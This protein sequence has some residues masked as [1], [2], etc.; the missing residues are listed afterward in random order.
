MT[1]VVMIAKENGHVLS[2]GRQ[3]PKVPWRRGRRAPCGIPKAPKNGN[4]V[5]SPEMRKWAR[6]YLGA[7]ATSFAGYHRGEGFWYYQFW[8]SQGMRFLFRDADKAMLFKLTWGG[9]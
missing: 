7:K 2:Q 6:K 4:L 1:E 9:K 3:K 5:L 8:G